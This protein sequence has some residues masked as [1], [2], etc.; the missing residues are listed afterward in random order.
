MPPLK[1]SL[2]EWRIGQYPVVA[3]AL[4]TLV[5]VLI[6]PQGNALRGLGNILVSNPLASATSLFGGAVVFFISLAFGES[7]LAVLFRK[8]TRKGYFWVSGTAGAFFI[9]FFSLAMETAGPVE[10]TLAAVIGLVSFVFTRWSTLGEGRPYSVACVVLVIAGTWLASGAGVIEMPSELGRLMLLLTA[11]TG[12]GVSWQ[13]K[14]LGLMSDISSVRAAGFASSLSGCV[15]AVILHY[16]FAIG[17]WG[18][19]IPANP[20]PSIFGEHWWVY[21]CSPEGVL[22]IF[23]GTYASA[24]LKEIYPVVMVTGNLLSSI[25]IGLVTTVVT[26]TKLLLQVAGVLLAII[27][28]AINTFGPKIQRR[29]TNPTRGK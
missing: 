2:L 5:G 14:T 28:V 23:F 21:T 12:F 15:S 19:V 8:D 1:D 26:L 22:I 13:F 16:I 18:P 11:V 29:I 27:G 9:T 4:A 7:K 6:P 10:A 24:K 17:N 3:L 25:G 20:W